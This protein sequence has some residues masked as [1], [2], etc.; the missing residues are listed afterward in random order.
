M[1][2]I[3][4][5]QVFK[6]DPIAEVKRMREQAENEGLFDYPV[7][8]LLLELAI[9]AI[10]FAIGLAVS[11][12]VLKFAIFI[13]TNYRF[14]MFL[15]ELGH[16]V[17]ERIRGQGDLI[18]ILTVG[19]PIKGFGVDAHNR[20]HRNPN[21]KGK[22][23]NIE[24]APGLLK[25]KT[26][27]ISKLQQMGPIVWLALYLPL[28]V[29]AYAIPATKRFLSEKHP[30][31]KTVFVLRWIAF[32]WI[33]TTTGSTIQ[34]FIALWAAFYAVGF[35]ASLNH[36]HRPVLTELHESYW[37]HHFYVTHNLKPESAIATWMLGGLNFHLEH[38][39]FPEIPSYKL[40]KVAKRVREF[41]SKHGLPYH[42]NSVGEAIMKTLG[43]LKGV[44][45]Q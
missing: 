6:E 19:L 5:P 14:V 8:T 1:N 45:Y 37:K 42:S 33:L 34:Y 27:R 3:A 44:Q 29:F 26:S 38:H 36:Y 40:H 15:H 20:H 35:L 43:A 31:L 30:V 25:P 12:S 32:I 2:A 22:D 21:T 4:K 41:A 10:A 23:P 39:V 24:R 28:S 7:Q 9:L 18:G 17:N 13:I 11:N 16:V